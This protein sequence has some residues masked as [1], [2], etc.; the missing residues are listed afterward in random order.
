MTSEPE[1]TRSAATAELGR[2]ELQ[3]LLSPIPELESGQ[4]LV[5]I[6]G[7]VASGCHSHP[8]PEVGYIVRG[9]VAI[10]FDD[11]ATPALRSGDPFLIP[12]GVI[13]NAR[14]IGNVTTKEAF[15]LRRIRGATPRDRLQVK[16]RFRDLSWD[17]AIPLVCGR[18]SYNAL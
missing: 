2:T 10:E 4:S 6:P 15:H 11:G 13:R 17:C 12:T 7:G 9:G 3:C 18:K 14:N 5:E 8:G 1:A 16:A